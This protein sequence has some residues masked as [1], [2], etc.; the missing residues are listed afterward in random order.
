MTINLQNNHY[1]ARSM[2]IGSI[3]IMTHKYLRDIKASNLK[4]CR[5]STLWNYFGIDYTSNGFA[6]MIHN[7]FVNKKIWVNRL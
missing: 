6:P 3:L 2:K 4:F 1:F 7:S 5:S